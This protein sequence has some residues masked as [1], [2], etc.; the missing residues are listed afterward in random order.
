MGRGAVRHKNNVPG[1]TDRGAG[2]RRA[3]LEGSATR[4]PQLARPYTAL[5]AQ[6]ANASTLGS[7]S[8]TGAKQYTDGDCCLVAQAVLFRPITDGISSCHPNQ[9]RNS[10]RTYR[11]G[12][13][14]DAP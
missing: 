12:R 1:L 9:P 14:F 13:Y 3:R 4:L 7:A 2:P 8:G 5:L 10:H 11:T 6:N